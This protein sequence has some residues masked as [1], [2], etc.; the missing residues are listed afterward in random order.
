[1][2]QNTTPE[3]QGIESGN[4]RMNARPENEVGVVRVKPEATGELWTIMKEEEEKLGDNTQGDHSTVSTEWSHDKKVF[5][6]RPSPILEAD[7]QTDPTSISL[8]DSGFLKDLNLD[9]KDTES[10]L[11]SI[12]AVHGSDSW[13]SSQSDSS[14]GES[15]SKGSL[16]TAVNPGKVKDVGRHFHDS[17]P[18][19]STPRFHDP[20]NSWEALQ[21]NDRIQ[22]MHG[23]PAKHTV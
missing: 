19:A 9:R 1:M 4:A 17:S 23:N 13:H 22:N 12:D 14:T 2:L 18:E 5:S 6:S 20:E 3:G 21:I 10:P 7:T 16:P 15:D 8:E 11:N